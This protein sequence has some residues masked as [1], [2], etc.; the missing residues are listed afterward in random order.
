MDLQVIVVGILGL[1]LL[2]IVHEAGHHVAARA[3][4]MRVIKFSIGVWTGDLASPAQGQHDGLPSRAH[5]V[6]GL[7][8]DRGDESLR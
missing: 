7:R 2:M 1:A 8:A 3:F 4:G 6:H 5:P